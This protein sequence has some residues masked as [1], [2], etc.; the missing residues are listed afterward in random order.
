MNENLKNATELY[1]LFKSKLEEIKGGVW[2]LYFLS[3]FC[4]VID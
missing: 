2:F 3:C 4:Y 1:Y